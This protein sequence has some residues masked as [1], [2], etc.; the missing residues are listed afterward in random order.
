M[1]VDLPVWIFQGS[2]HCSNDSRYDRRV[3]LSYLYLFGFIKLPQGQ[4]GV[5]DRVDMDNFADI[6]LNYQKLGRLSQDQY[7]GREKSD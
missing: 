5:L 2:L 6:F 3:S 4:I 1:F 7:E